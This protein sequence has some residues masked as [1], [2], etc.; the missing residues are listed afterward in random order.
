MAKETKIII[1][2]HA[3]LVIKYKHQHEKIHVYIRNERK[4]GHN[5]LNIHGCTMKE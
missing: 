4:L 1:N 2:N 5:K 3:T